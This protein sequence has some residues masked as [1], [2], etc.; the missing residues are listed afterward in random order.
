VHA[1]RA[2]HG[3]GEQGVEPLEGRAEGGERVGREREGAGVARARLLLG[4][5]G[6]RR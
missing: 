4:R 1:A 6:R 3:F 2:D 5:H